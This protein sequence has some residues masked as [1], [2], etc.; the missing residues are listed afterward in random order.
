MVDFKDLTEYR[1][2]WKARLDTENHHTAELMLRAIE[3]T[4]VL[5]DAE[6]QIQD[7]ISLANAAVMLRWA[8]ENG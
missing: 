6:P 3:N 4:K 5:E 1:D 8:A 7:A 2:Y